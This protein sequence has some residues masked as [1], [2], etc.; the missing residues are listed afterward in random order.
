MH[1]RTK[2][3]FILFLTFFFLCPA[4]V[5]SIPLSAAAAPASGNSFQEEAEA[6]KEMPVESNARE[7]WPAG[8]LIGAQS[9]ILMEANTGAILYEKNIHDKLYP[10]SIT[11]I[12]TALIA[13]E[14]CPLDDIVTYSNEAV[15]SIDWLTIPIWGSRRVNRLPWSSLFTGFWSDPPMKRETLSENIS[16]GA[17]IPSWT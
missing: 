17:L 16:A 2:H 13:M 3:K 8:P 6:R 9:A 11:K 10:A 14:S 4:L 15:N 7:N 5:F 12:L 1:H